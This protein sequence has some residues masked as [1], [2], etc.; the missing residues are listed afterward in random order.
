MKTAVTILH[1]IDEIRNQFPP[2]FER[3]MDRC[4]Q[5][6]VSRLE[7]LDTITFEAIFILVVSSAVLVCNV[8]AR[9]GDV[10][11]GIAIFLIG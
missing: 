4:C 10:S 3:L 6:L 11:M 8:S 1:W 7:T 9:A 2:T 5:A